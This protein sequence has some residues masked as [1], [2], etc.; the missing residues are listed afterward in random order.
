MP[1]SVITFFGFWKWSGIS[2]NAW[3]LT[4]WATHPYS[5]NQGRAVGAVALKKNNFSALIQ[6]NWSFKFYSNTQNGALTEQIHVKLAKKSALQSKV[7]Y[8]LLGLEL[9]NDLLRACWQHNACL[10]SLDCQSDWLSGTPFGGGSSS[11]GPSITESDREWILL[12]TTSFEI[13]INWT[14]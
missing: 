13:V 5:G 1:S 14:V 6:L 2:G 9:I 7:A 4:F 3:F 10:T 8:F 11:S 12:A